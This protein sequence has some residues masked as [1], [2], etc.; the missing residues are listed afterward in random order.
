MR[1]ITLRGI[2]EDVESMVKDEARTRGVSLNKAFVSL[3]IRGLERK[4]QSP[5]MGA[6]PKKGEFRQFL[7]LWAEDETAAFNEALEEQRGV[8]EEL[9][10]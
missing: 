9:W 5:R 6:T 10:R 3:L 7:G 1:Q 8:D 2:P 4:P